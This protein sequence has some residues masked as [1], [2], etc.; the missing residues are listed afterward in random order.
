[1]RSTFLLLFVVLLFSSNNACWGDVADEINPDQPLTQKQKDEL[2]AQAMKDMKRYKDQYERG[3]KE[4]Y[5]KAVKYEKAIKV[6]KGAITDKDQ[7]V[8]NHLSEGVLM[9]PNIIRT[10]SGAIKYI[11]ILLKGD[12]NSFQFFKSFKTEQERKTNFDEAMESALSRISSGNKDA[13]D[14]VDEVRKRSK[15]CPRA[16]KEA[17]RLS[18]KK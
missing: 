1:M 3:Q 5:R 18:S 6:T 9:T 14:I 8:V 13:V 16:A 7:E 11:K 10:E 2:N 4:A 17:L 15:D 12:H